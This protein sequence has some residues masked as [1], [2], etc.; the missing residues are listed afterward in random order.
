MTNWENIRANISDLEAA[1]EDAAREEAA[2]AVCVFCGCII[3]DPDDICEDYDG[4]P[5]CRDC[6]DDRCAICDR[7]GEVIDRDCAI[8]VNDAD[9]L[10]CADCADRYFYQC[11]ECGEYF[12]ASGIAL[13]DD[14]RGTYICYDCRNRY[15]YVQCADCGCIG[16]S[17]DMNW[18]DREE[19]YYC[20]GCYS[21]HCGSDNL[22]DYGYKPRPRFLCTDDDITG[23]R[24][25][26]V[27]LEIDDGDD[28]NDCADDLAGL[29]DDIYCKHDGSLGDEGVE[30]VT[31]PGTLRYHLF[32]LPWGHIVQTAR[33]H[34]YTSHDAGSCGLHVH[35]GR[36]ALPD[37]APEKLIAL[38]DAVWGELV[39]FSRR[40]AR[41]LNHW[42]QK[43]DAGITVHDDADTAK[44]KTNKA[45]GR[46]RYQA[47]NLQNR[48]TIEFRMFRGSLVLQTVRATLQC[49]DILCEYATRHTLADCAGATWEDIRA[50]GADMNDFCAYCEK[51]GI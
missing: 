8:W 23:N 38:V 28:A 6:F 12:F 10:V 34:G 31:H 24:F 30:I 44:D 47:V 25:Y 26:G 42:A 16:Q 2:A 7:C 40:D 51:R 41:Q 45:R 21:D 3:E 22:H 50:A 29:T 37:D 18:S 32:N 9:E 33:E 4:D 13:E 46:G 5:C 35:V 15:E 14:D 39:V 17:W 1:R 20:D 43:P 19:D 11:D 36:D 27:E 49:V 48:A